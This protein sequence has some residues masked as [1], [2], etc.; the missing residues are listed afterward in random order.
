MRILIAGATGV[1]VVESVAFP[2]HEEAAQAFEQLEHATREFG[3]ESVIL[4]FGRAIARW[5]RPASECGQGSS[6]RTI[7]LPWW[8][9]VQRGLLGQLSQM[10][11][12]AL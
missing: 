12:R 8:E 6:G 3:G 5:K 9:S 7:S 4:R 11:A 2:L 1:L 10:C